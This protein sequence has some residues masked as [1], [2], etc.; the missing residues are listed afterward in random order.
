MQKVSYHNQL[1]LGQCFIGHFSTCYRPQHLLL[2][3]WRQETGQTR[4]LNQYSCCLLA[5]EKTKVRLR[6]DSQSCGV[7][8]ASRGNG[9]ERHSCRTNSY[10][11]IIVGF[12]S[13]FLSCPQYRHEDPAVAGRALSVQD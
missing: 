4:S 1:W 13:L 10:R 5:T 2:K 3:C 8:N 6:T 12:Y 11:K 9:T 7:L